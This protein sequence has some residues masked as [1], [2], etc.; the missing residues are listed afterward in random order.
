M[1]SPLG[2]GLPALE[3]LA[4]LVLDHVQANGESAVRDI[5]TRWPVTRQQ[6]RLIV[7]LLAH[8]GLLQLRTAGSGELYA[9]LRDVASAA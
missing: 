8:D 2:S 1:H 3:A 4:V 7:R 6:V 5:P 9:R